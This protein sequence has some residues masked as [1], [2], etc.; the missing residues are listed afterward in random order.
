M[1]TESTTAIEWTD[2]TLNFATGCSKVNRD[3]KFC[4]MYAEEKHYGKDPATVKRTKPATWKKVIAQDRYGAY[5]WRSGSKVFVCSFT[6]FF[7]PDLDGYREEAWRLMAHRRDLV[8]QVLTKRPQRIEEHLPADFPDK[9]PNL[10]LGVSTGHQAAY[11]TFWPILAQIPAAVRF[12][13]AEPLTEPL[14]LGGHDVLPDWVIAG[15]ES[16]QHPRVRPMEPDWPRYLRD[17]CESYNIPFFF[18]QW[19]Q[20]NAA[21][22][23]V[24]NKMDAGNLLDGREHDAFPQPRKE[25]CQP[26]AS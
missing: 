24:R 18:K 23:R 20:H 5:K 13:S 3:C 6:D 4:Y 16:G 17:Q 11:D 9:W 2:H 26:T 19:G 10:W 22:E 12:L 21:G 8:F 1:A 15:G 25:R 14:I 7:H